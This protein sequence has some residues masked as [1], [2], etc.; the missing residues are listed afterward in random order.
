MENIDY[1]KTYSAFYNP[2]K[3][4]F[5]LVGIPKMNFLMI[6]GSGDPNTSQ[7]FQDAVEALYAVSYKLKFMVKKGPLEID[8]KVM[9]LEGLWWAADM[10]AFTTSRKD[11]W[12]WT[13]M[14][15]QPDIIQEDMVKDALVDVERKKNPTALPKIRF[16]AYEE[17]LSAQILY[18]GP[19]A[20]EGP[21][22]ERLHTFITENR[23]KPNGKHHEIYLSDV[24]RVDPSRNKTIIRQPILQN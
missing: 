4:E 9:P 10:Q 21:I 24:R 7:S 18:I 22:I 23:S 15:M 17:G 8:Y 6:D 16:E 19:Y 3:K 11:D 12:L 5:S 14:I 2:S 1:K 20:E 13:L